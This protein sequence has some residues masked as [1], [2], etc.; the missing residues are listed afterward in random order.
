MTK[1]PIIE[2]QN[3]T[4]EFDVHTNSATTLKE[5][6]LRG[7]SH[8]GERSS[9][10]ALDQ[11]SWKIE[12]GKSY[13]IVGGNGAG[14][15]TLL[16]L[17]TGVLQ[18]TS[19]QVKVNGRVAALLELG[20]GFHHELTGMENLFL[21]GSI[22]GL[23][24]E[25]IIERI[26]PVLEFSEL[27]R[28]IHT[29]LKRY[30]SGMIVRLGFALAATS[31]ADI[32]IIDEVLAVG[33]SSFRVKCIHKLNELREQGKTVI[34][35]SHV[36]DH[37]EMLAEEVMYLEKGTVKKVGPPWEVLIDYI[38]S[39]SKPEKVEMEDDASEDLTEFFG[40]DVGA[41]V[42]AMTSSQLGV[43]FK[44]TKARI[45]SFVIKD[46]KNEPIHVIPLGGRVKMEVGFE[47]I[48]KLEGV[49]VT[50]GFAGFEDL[51]VLFLGSHLQGEELNGEPEKY[52]LTIECDQLPL[53]PNR[54]KISIGIGNPE[55]TKDFYDLHLEVYS[56]QVASPS[57]LQNDPE[58][59]GVMLP[60]GRF[61]QV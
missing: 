12:A 21:Q 33:D 47:V 26:D 44:S 11:V 58:N 25:E 49:D 37:V 30:S 53:M 3:V 22:L 43:K 2:L 1:Q 60:P 7:L 50:V 17:I 19:G 36:L 20:A 40:K 61:E 52:L 59:N 45:R 32:F 13:A 57:P 31:D 18:P 5:M 15:S 10:K 55:N 42:I 35:V 8:R 14:K 23:D 46:E 54:F 51:G 27:E 29:P 41:Q 9:M 24:R 28:F 16:K 56:L 6:A 38:A 39:F 48:E 34:I 4:K